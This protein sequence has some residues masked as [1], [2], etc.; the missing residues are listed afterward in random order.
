MKNALGAISHFVLMSLLVSCQTDSIAPIKADCPLVKNTT[1][2]D[3]LTS[4]ELFGIQAAKVSGNTLLIT[5]NYGGG[6]DPNHTFELYIERNLRLNSAVPY[7][8][9]RVVFNTTDYCKR[10]GTKEFC[11][12][13]TQFK[14]EAKA[15]KIRI[16]GF[17][18]E[19][20]F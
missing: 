1:N 9:G 2:L 19:I 5:F 14:N 6:C 7:F 15:G 20:D 12:D 18:K 16:R 11:F 17:S 3:D 8:E 4:V 13:L 10:L